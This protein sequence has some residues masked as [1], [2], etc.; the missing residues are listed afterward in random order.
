MST[1]IA[2]STRQSSAKLH[3]TEVLSLNYTAKLLAGGQVGEGH[4]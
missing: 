1:K 3:G 2:V 4:T